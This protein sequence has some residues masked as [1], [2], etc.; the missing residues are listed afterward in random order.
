M[1]NFYW[2]ANTTPATPA[3]V[4]EVSATPATPAALPLTLPEGHPLVA[5]ADAR[6]I[7]ATPVA[8]DAEPVFTTSAIGTPTEVL[9]DLDTANA[10][11]EVNEDEDSAPAPDAPADVTPVTEAAQVTEAPVAQA[12]VSTPEP[13]VTAPEV[14]PAPVTPAPTADVTPPAAP[15]AF[16]TAPPAFTPAPAPLTVLEQVNAQVLA[17]TVDI[18]LLRKLWVDTYGE[19][20][21]LNAPAASSPLDF[22]RYFLAAAHADMAGVV[23]SVVLVRNREVVASAFTSDLDA[24]GIMSVLSQ[25]QPGDQLLGY[26]AAPTAP[27]TAA[28]CLRG[29]KLS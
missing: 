28:G 4:P 8:E 5:E 17:Q 3:F 18:R 22:A 24:T 2:T 25:V 13:E 27:A 23:F 11:T 20:P 10:A 29:L 1:K 14:S 19:V 26:A 9:I 21:L 12:P 7:L 15:P 6:A 16:V